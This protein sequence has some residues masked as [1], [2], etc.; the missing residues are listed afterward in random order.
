MDTLHKDPLAYYT[1][2]A[3]CLSEGNMFRTK[4][5]EKLKTHFMRSELFREVYGF[6][7]NKRKGANTPELLGCGCISYLNDNRGSHGGD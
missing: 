7:D 5:L 4:V 3:S 6:R 2:L 1:H